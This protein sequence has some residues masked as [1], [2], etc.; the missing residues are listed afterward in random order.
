MATKKKTTTD[1]RDALEKP[2]TSQPQLNNELSAV[3]VKSISAIEEKV[4]DAGFFIDRKSIKHNLTN[5]NN[6]NI[7]KKPK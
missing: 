5:K 4:E 2:T 1:A 7:Y 3:T 6:Y